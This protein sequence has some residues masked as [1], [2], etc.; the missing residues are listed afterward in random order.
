MLT[1]IQKMKGTTIQ[2]FTAKMVKELNHLYHENEIRQFCKLMLEHVL[3]VNT[4]ILLTM[5]DE[6]LSASDLS[7]LNIM[8]E[9]L[10]QHVPIQ[11]IIGKTEF[12]GLEIDLNP[13]V[14]IPRPETEELVDWILKDNPESLKSLLDIGTGSGC[15]ALALKANMPDTRVSAWDFSLQALETARYNAQQLELDIEFE[16]I[17]VLNFQPAGKKYSCIVSNPPYV[18][19]LEKEM[20]DKNVLEHEPHTAL[21]VS[22][23]DPLVFYRTIAKHALEILEKK[24]QLF[25][26]IN[27]YLE[28]EMVDML[29]SL[30]YANIECRKDINGKARMM[31]AILI[32]P[33]GMELL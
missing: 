27:E 13:S 20:M 22:D 7:R 24:G 9:R 10:Q 19:N 16:N 31:R 23:N 8:A 33:E 18:R 14:L 29:T 4:T 15:I 30:G 26:E 25:F 6:I 2:Q 32:N 3:D 17:D 21:F 5:S 28:R 11:Y 1:K 12:Y